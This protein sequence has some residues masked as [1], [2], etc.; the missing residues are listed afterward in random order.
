MVK[1]KLKLSA[2]EGNEECF[3]EVEL[4]ENGDMNVGMRGQNTRGEIHYISAQIPNPV[5]A[6]GDLDDYK[7]LAQ[8]YEVLKKIK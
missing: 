5:N 2:L 6:G 8:I 7:I 4:F 3:L 1:R